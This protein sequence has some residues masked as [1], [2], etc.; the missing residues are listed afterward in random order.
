MTSTLQELLE[1]E[2]VMIQRPSRMHGM[3][4]VVL[5]S[6]QG[7]FVFLMDKSFCYNP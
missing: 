6:L 2:R 4:Y 3:L 7:Y 5:M 1:M